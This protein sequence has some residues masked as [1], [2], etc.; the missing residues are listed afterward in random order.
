MRSYNLSTGDSYFDHMQ[1]GCHL[2]LPDQREKEPQQNYPPYLSSVTLRH[3]IE[4]APLPATDKPQLAAMTLQQLKDLMQS[5]GKPSF[6]AKQIIDWCNKG[7]L[8]PDDMKNIPADV[9]DKLHTELL[10]QPLRLI[11]R[12]CSADGTRKYVFALK[13]GRFAGKMVESVFIPEERRGTVCISSQVGCVLDCPFCH[14]GTQKFEANL[15]A[16]EIIAQ[17]LAIKADLHTEP[18][19]TELHSDI[20]HIVYMGMGLIG[21]DVP[22]VSI[23]TRIG[24]VTPESPASAAGM[25]KVTQGEA[26]DFSRTPDSI[27]W[28]TGD[29]IK[30]INGAPVTGFSEIVTAA[31]L[32][33][34]QKATIEIE[35]ILPDGT[36]ENYICFAEPIQLDPDVPLTRFGYQPFQSALIDHVLPNSPAEEHGL[37][38]GDRIIKADGEWVDMGSFSTHIQSMKSG[39]S[40]Q[41]FLER[42]GKEMTLAL[43]THER[44]SFNDI[45]FTPSLNSI[46]GIKDNQAQK[47][48]LKN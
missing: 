48:I 5:W 22:K 1:Q 41:L 13:R 31:V 44:G 26:T 12:E 37:L 3:M 17:V 20:S 32:N 2:N 25:F 29:R 45:Y 40:T 47:V 43:T 14:T 7:I 35:R 18:L 34:G 28:K 10:C 33:K 42:D 36:I 24:Q 9:R 30:T 11:R 23:E 4:H 46:I 19:S 16:G 27:G 6:R 8:N 21:G 15:N 39:E 38:S